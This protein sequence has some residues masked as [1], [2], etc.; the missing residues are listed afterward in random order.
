MTVRGVLLGQ[1]LRILQEEEPDVVEIC[2]KYTAMYLGGLLREQWLPSFNYRPT[3]VGLSCER[4]DENM[5]AYL[6]KGP[7]GV[8]FS[9]MYMKWLYFP[10][11]DHHIAN[12]AHTA[13]ELAKAA[14][15]HKVRRGVWLGPMGVD[16]GSFSPER[17]STEKQESLSSAA[18]NVAVCGP[19][20][21]R[22][23][24]RFADHDCQGTGAAR[25]A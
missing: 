13:A 5:A 1:I 10:M 23:K 12:S 22:E 17:R 21:A 19:A 7:L 3:V 6:A 8:K 24:F 9:R 2:D 18:F 4:M 25:D 20:G 11:F 14:R 16:I 15:G